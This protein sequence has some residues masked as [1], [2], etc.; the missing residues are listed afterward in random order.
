MVEKRAEITESQDEYLE[1]EF[2]DDCKSDAE[3]FRTLI[4]EHR[5]MPR[6]LEFDKYADDV[7]E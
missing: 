2:G 4:R 7:P 1:R 6:L 3:V 5:R